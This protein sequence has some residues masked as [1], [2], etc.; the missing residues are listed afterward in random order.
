M[1]RPLRIEF[2]GA[3]YHVTAHGNGGDA[4]FYDDE[5]RMAFLSVLGE[6]CAEADWRVLCY[7]LLDDHLHLV[8]ATD[9]ATLS[10]GM[11]QLFGVYSQAFNRRHGRHGHLFQGRYKSILVETSVYLAQLCAYVLRSPVADGLVKGAKQW[12][13]SSY[14]LNGGT[15]QAAWFDPAPLW[16][17][18]GAKRSKAT[19]AVATLAR[20]N[21]PALQA[22]GQ[23][24][25]G[26]D[27]FAAK[28][29]KKAGKLS[30]Q[31]SRRTRAA[32]S[33]DIA[34]YD[35]RYPQRTEA[36]ARACLE[37]Q[38]S[39]SDVARYYDVYPSTVSRVVQKFDAQNNT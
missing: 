33:P 14:R 8:I 38:H 37:G 15:E 9:R 34:W 35:G 29:A 2:A 18:L 3:V 23:L 16:D 24:C 26:G 11:R 36:M 19:V 30:A 39:R 22:R 20:K 31:H 25:Y 7:C 27:A 1:A 10:R 17:E 13:W 5:D 28:L 21:Q 12:P 4:V 6:V 32:L